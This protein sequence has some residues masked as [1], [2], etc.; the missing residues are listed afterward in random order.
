MNNI[1]LNYKPFIP[2]NKNIICSNWISNPIY[3]NNINL[4]SQNLHNLYLA[5]IKKA[6]EDMYNSVINDIKILSLE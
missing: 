1:L 3:N 5:Q 6:N 2:R 4:E